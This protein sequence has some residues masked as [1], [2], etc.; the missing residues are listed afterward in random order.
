[1]GHWI[2]RSSDILHL[3]FVM[4]TVPALIVRL[5]ADPDFVAARS[6]VGEAFANRDTVGYNIA[7]RWQSQELLRIAEARQAIR[8]A[9]RA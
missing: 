6:L 3:E 9:A 1:M 7:R 8:R 4:G 2:G 5:L